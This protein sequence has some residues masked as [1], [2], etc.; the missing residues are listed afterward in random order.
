MQR[1]CSK[2]L[3]VILCGLVLVG[4]FVEA[5]L[6]A[7]QPQ[8]PNLPPQISGGRT[9]RERQIQR[10]MQLRALQNRG[11]GRGVQRGQAPIILNGG[12]AYGT[13]GGAGPT[14]D[15][16]P[17]DAKSL[18]RQRSA[19]RKAEA[20]RKR[21]EQKRLADERAAQKKADK[22]A[23]A[24]EAQAAKEGKAVNEKKAETVAK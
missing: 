6:A 23:K 10:A 12:P 5:L 9:A 21:A 3:A 8:L 22:L 20:R 14:A 18:K 2:L 15:A 7:G 19:E 4:P 17:Q 16:P 11:G 13:G 1:T 24:K